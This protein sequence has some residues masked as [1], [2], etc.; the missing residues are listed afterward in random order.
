[1]KNGLNLTGILT[2]AVLVTFDDLPK[3]YGEVR[4]VCATIVE[5][6]HGRFRPGYWMYT[7]LV[8]KVEGDIVLTLNSTYKIKGDMTQVSLPFSALGALKEGAPP[9]AVKALLEAG[10]KIAEPPVVQESGLN[11]NDETDGEVL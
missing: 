6:F 4:I 5:D 9:R 1:M 8:K 3:E 10:Y 11:D 7:S 2:D